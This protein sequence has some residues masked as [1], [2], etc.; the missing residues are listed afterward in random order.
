MTTVVRQGAPQLPTVSGSITPSTRDEMD[1]AVQA[2]QS[3]KNEWA[4]L[5]VSK[6]ID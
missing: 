1:A 3:H 2:L 5:Q 6:R 4:S